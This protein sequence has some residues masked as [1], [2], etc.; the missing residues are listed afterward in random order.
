MKALASWILEGLHSIMVCMCIYIYSYVIYSIL[1]YR[2]QY[3]SAIFHGPWCIMVK[4]IFSP[5]PAPV[6]SLAHRRNHVHSSAGPGLRIGHHG[7][8]PRGQ[9]EVAPGCRVTPVFQGHQP[10]ES[11][12]VGLFI[13]VTSTVGCCLST[14]QLRGSKQQG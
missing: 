6:R 11:A 4:K 5:P 1:L 9:E 3:A 14:S 13:L 7:H 8:D 10:V 12:G 2:I